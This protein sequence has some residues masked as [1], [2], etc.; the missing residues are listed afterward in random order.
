MFV[1]AV[2]QAKRYI[3]PR[4]VLAAAPLKMRVQFWALVASGVWI[5][6]VTVSARAEDVPSQTWLN[7]WPVIFA[8]L[9]WVF[10][11]GVVWAKFDALK[12]RLDSLEGVTVKKDV[13]AESIN[14]LRTEI[15]GLRELLER[16]H[17]GQRHYGADE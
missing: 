9:T 1:G 12:A 4:I 7:Y 14:T 5:A 6:S 11:A 2:I 15:R 13:L 16:D 8:T 3:S 17:R 10:S